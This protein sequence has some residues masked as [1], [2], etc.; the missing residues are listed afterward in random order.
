M[1]RIKNLVELWWCTT[2]S[3]QSSHGEIPRNNHT[4]LMKCHNSKFPWGGGPWQPKTVK[5]SI[6]LKYTEISQGVGVG[7]QLKTLRLGGKGRQ[8][9]STKNVT[10]NVWQSVLRRQGA[11]SYNNYLLDFSCWW[12]WSEVVNILVLFAEFWENGCF[13]WGMDSLFS[14]EVWDGGYRFWSGSDMG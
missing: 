12:S 6:N 8:I 11:A 10:L 2:K 3:L 13:Q 14:F 4:L 7:C 9:F 1:T 5:D